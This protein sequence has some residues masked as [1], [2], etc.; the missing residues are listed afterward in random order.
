MERGKHGLGH[1]IAVFLGFGIRSRSFY[2]D[3]RTTLCITGWSS[4][5]FLLITALLS[6]IFVEGGGRK[7][8][9]P[10]ET[11]CKESKKKRR[12]RWTMFMPD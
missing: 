5:S 2:P 11:K 10:K 12:D 9:K 4:A 1:E 8:A 3:K 6:C 7:K